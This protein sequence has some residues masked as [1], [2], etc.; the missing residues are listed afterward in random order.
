MFEGSVGKKTKQNFVQVGDAAGES[1]QVGDE[2][3]V[4]AN[5]DAQK[6]TKPNSFMFVDD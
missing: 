1:W 5:P 6:R 2:G 4:Q 3:Q